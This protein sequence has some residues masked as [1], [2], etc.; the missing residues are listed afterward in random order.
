MS[1]RGGTLAA[2][3]RRLTRQ[4]VNGAIV[5]TRIAD[6]STLVNKDPQAKQVD[7]VT[8]DNGVISTVYTF[9]IA[10]V[11]ISI[12][13]ADGN[14]TNIA[15][16][17]LNAFKAEAVANGL[18][19]ITQST[20]VLTITGNIPGNTYTVTDSDSNLTAASVTSAAEAE[21]VGFG[22]ALISSGFDTEN[23]T[24]F[25]RMAK[26][27]AFTAQVVTGDYTFV[28]GK[29]LT[30]EV[31]D[32]HTG[33]IIAFGQVI[34]ATSKAATSAALI[35]ELNAALP[36]DSVLAAAGGGSDD[37]D[38]TAEVAGLQFSVAFGSDDAANVLVSV[39][40]TT[41]PSVST[42]LLL[43]FA[44]ISAFSGD[45]E[46]ASISDA[47]A[48]Y[49]ANAGVRALDKGEMFVTNSENPTNGQQVFVELDGT[50]SDFAKFFVADSATRLAMPRGVLKW[51][52]DSR[53]STDQLAVLTVNR[54]NIAV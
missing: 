18:G 46:P 21:A 31:K 28:S 43:A 35:V 30:M 29:I 32:E 1:I 3:V 19:V 27:S 37:I 54:Y 2:D 50:G 26:S 4:G 38:L 13:S 42:S 52:R 33:Q 15:T 22:R 45:E 44:G 11:S 41:G 20:N 8:V 39:T 40:E 10:D 53:D 5:N 17:L 12:T 48:S 16:Q 7:T 36:A 47:T 9:E 6:T 25:G 24:K 49:P 23:V 34:S 51:V 14:T